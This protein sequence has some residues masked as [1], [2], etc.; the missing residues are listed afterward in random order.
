MG[1]PK[2]GKA[3]PALAGIGL[4]KESMLASGSGN[5]DNQDLDEFQRLGEVLPR[6]FAGF[7]KR[8]DAETIA[9]DGVAEIAHGIVSTAT[10]LHSAACVCDKPTV[11]ACLWTIRRQLTAAITTWRDAVPGPEKGGSK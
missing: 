11:E 1:F 5:E 2:R 9:F 6:V 10:S 4:P 8:S 3:A 7:A